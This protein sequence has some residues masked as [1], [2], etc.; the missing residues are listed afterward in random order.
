MNWNLLIRD[1]NVQPAPDPVQEMLGEGRAGGRVPRVPSVSAG[2]LCAWSMGK[3]WH[4]AWGRKHLIA[5]RYHPKQET[6]GL[7]FQNQGVE[8]R[9]SCEIR[10]YGSSWACPPAV[11]H[12]RDVHWELKACIGSHSRIS[13]LW[14]SLTHGLMIL[15]PNEYTWGPK[16]KVHASCMLQRLK[17]NIS[18]L[19]QLLPDKIQEAQPCLT[20]RSMHNFFLFY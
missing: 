10:G 7:G 5:N 17:R 16:W 13:V 9:Q 12:P 14:A 1:W 2:H 3:P 19:C 4:C 18:C 15:A 20:L 8:G 11:G 6:E